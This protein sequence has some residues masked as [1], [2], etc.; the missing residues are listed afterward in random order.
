M[1]PLRLHDWT[2]DGD[3]V[4]A[5]VVVPLL[6]LRV[7]VGAGPPSD[8][9]NNSVIRLISKV[10]LFWCLGVVWVVD[11]ER[12]RGCMVV[13]V[14][15][16]CARQPLGCRL[17][18]PETSYPWWPSF[19]GS[20]SLGARSLR[21]EIGSRI[22]AAAAPVLGPDHEFHFRGPEGIILA[23]RGL[24]SGVLVGD[25]MYLLLTAVVSTGV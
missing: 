11:V 6:S 23:A 15:D 14:V 25:V 2:D 20:P 18:A 10:F 21:C 9:V 1:G 5:P 17:V 19:P 4:D 3:V 22:C 12:G 16:M 8:H 13:G 7:E 24:T